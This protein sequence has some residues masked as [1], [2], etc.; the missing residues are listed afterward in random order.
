MEKKNKQSDRLTVWV[1][2]FDDE[3]WRQLF[4]CENLEDYEDGKPFLR[5]N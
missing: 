4:R 2:S 3:D 1:E 5:V